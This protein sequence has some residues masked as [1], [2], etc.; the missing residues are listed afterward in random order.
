[1][2]RG[3]RREERTRLNLLDSRLREELEKHW[4]S[5]MARDTICRDHKLKNFR[6]TKII[7]KYSGSDLLNGE[8]RR[9]CLTRA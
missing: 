5:F 6:V 4:R 9:S 8:V 1:M 2:E 3:R 7:V